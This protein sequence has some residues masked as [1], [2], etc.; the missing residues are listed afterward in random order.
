LPDHQ[1]HRLLNFAETVAPD[2]VAQQRLGA[3]VM[4]RRI[5]FEG[6]ATNVQ[7]LPFGFQLRRIADVNANAGQHTASCWTSCWV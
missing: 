5:E 3:E 2:G 1:R 7:R 6:A 4:T